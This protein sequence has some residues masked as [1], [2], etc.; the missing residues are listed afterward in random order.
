MS[1]QPMEWEK[2]VANDATDKGFISRI[3]K[4]HIQHNSKKANH[5][6]EKW[7]KYLNRH[8]SKEDI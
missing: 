1:R 7:A 3:H 6:M 8:F 5:P 4:Q 2:R